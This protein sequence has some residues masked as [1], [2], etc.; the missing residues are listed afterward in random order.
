MIFT[1][2]NLTSTVKTTAHDLM[3]RR[4]N[5]NYERFMQEKADIFQVT[6]PKAQ[7]IFWTMN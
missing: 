5:A 3:T 2:N 4:Q 6:E 1:A 7:A